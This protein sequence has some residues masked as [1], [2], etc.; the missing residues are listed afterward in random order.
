MINEICRQLHNK[1]ILILGFGKEGKST[2]QFIRKH[3]P[4]KELSIYDKKVIEEELPYVIKHCSDSFL[5]LIAEYDMVIKSPGIVLNT[6]D[7]NLLSKVTSQTDLFLKYYGAQTVGVTG[8]KGKSTT[9]SLLYHILHNSNKDALLVGNIG[10]P[11][12]DALEN[13][14]QDTRVVFELSSH[15]LEYAKNSPHV[16]V[17]LNIYQEHLD[18]YGTFEKYREAKENI[19]KNQNKGDLF[20]YN[21]EFIKSAASI[22]ANTITISTRADDSD[23]YIEDNRICYKG[24]VIEINEEELMLKGQHNLY[25]IGA[26]YVLSDLFGVTDEEFYA[27]VKTFRP[28][29][30]RM[31]YVAE[32]AGV[33]FYNDSISTICETTIQAV[34]SIKNIETIILGGMDRGIDYQPLVD[35]LME[36]EIRNIILMPDTGLRIRD[37]ISGLHKQPKDKRIFVVSDVGEAVAVAKKETGCGKTCLFSPAA[38]SYGFFKNFEERGE[39]FKSLVLNKAGL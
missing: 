22:K 11:V 4:D 26:A 29:P 25:N 3:F 28:L 23:M 36:S 34:K 10:I 16:G 18:H 15:Q 7:E 21:K 27:A 39:I 8:T 14:H 37:I 38:A 6:S 1:K 2:Y 30:H 32:V 17:F 5:E 35:F 9:A 13:I 31:E 12:F 33:K 19:Y 20:I 24:R